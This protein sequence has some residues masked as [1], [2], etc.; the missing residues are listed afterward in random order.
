MATKFS[1]VIPTRGRP[2]QLAMCLRSL[3]ALD[4]P[5][6][7]FEVIVVDDGSE[8]P[9]PAYHGPLAVTWLRQPPAGPA[10]AR[11]TGVAQARG[12]LL[13]FTDDDCAPAPDWLQ[14]LELRLTRHPAHLVGGAVINALPEN[15]YSTASQQL[16]SYLYTY[17][18][19]D[20]GHA[21]FF[22]S[23]NMA[24]A[25][26]RFR[27]I[28][29]FDE[30]SP[31]AAAEDRELCDRWRQRG[32]PMCYAADAVVHHAHQLT[33]RS[34]WRQHFNYG[35]GAH[36]FHIT[37]QQRGGG[38]I[39]VEPWKF[40]RDLLRYPFAVSHPRAF[41]QTGL[42]FLSQIANALGFFRERYG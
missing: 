21:R 10:T 33:L 32:G 41:R 15:P 17:Y 12:E 5:R 42:L 37:R 39:R 16:A 19:A 28:G 22:T 40:Y 6:D 36:Y 20:A 26:A 25:T 1:I 30:T 29:G 27:E 9:L 2:A 3:E 34:F 38:P 18:N 31:R 11:N 4:Y 35:R 13:A 7:R 8:Q 23:N 24:L 14:T